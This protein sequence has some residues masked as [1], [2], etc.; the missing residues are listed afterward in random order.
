MALTSLASISATL[1]VGGQIKGVG[2]ALTSLVSIASTLNVG[3]TV[4]V[5][6]GVTYNPAI[7]AQQGVLSDATIAPV[8]ITAS[9]ASQA[10]LDF[11]G[12]V[13]STAS[14]SLTGANVVGLV[15]VWY[16]GVAGNAAGWLP[17]FKDTIAA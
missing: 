5:S 1:N 12:A 13:I 14:L 2:I 7:V 3:D 17:I 4:T 9:T 15:R 11:R 8:R 10:F 16:Q 6:S